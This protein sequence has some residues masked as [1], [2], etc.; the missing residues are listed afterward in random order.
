MTHGLNQLC[1]SRYGPMLFNRHDRFIGRSLALYGEYSEAEAVL[2]KTLVR[3]GGV[4]VE[5]GANIGVFTVLMAKLAGESG[6]VYAYEP[7]R[8]I[9]QLLCANI[10]LNGLLNVHTYHAGAGA[11]E[12][13]ATIAPVDYRKDGNFGGVELSPLGATGERVPVLTLD[14]H[15][16]DRRLD[17]L[18]IDAEGMEQAILSGAKRTIETHRPIIYLENDRPGQQ[19]SL[20][21][22][23]EAQ[24]YQLRPHR[25]PLFN[26]RNFFKNPHNAFGAICSHNLLALPKER[27]YSI[28]T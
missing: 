15:F 4:I 7:Q 11:K 25:P 6:R 1:E 24:D 16:S 28:E 19:A 20:K 2:L 18:K 27:A 3:P 23:L 13:V 22:L 17:L 21:T 12:A 10:A 14:E 8:I 9:H 5:A 26:P